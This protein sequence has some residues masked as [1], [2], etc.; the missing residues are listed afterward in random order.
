[1]KPP[2]LNRAWCLTSAKKME[3]D[4]E[5]KKIKIEWVMSVSLVQQEIMVARWSTAIS[6]WVTLTKRSR[7]AASTSASFSASTVQRVPRGNVAEK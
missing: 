2:K 7:V 5:V 3:L 4:I 6:N 1:M